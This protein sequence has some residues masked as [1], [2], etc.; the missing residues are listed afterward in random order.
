MTV[1]RAGYS[2]HGSILKVEDAGNTGTFA[3]IQ[4]VTKIEGLDIK[5]NMEESTHHESPNGWKQQAPTTIDAGQVTFELNFMPTDPTHNVGLGLLRNLTLREFKRFQLWF[6]SPFLVD[7][8][9]SGWVTNVKISLPVKGLIKA[10]VT[11]DV[12][13][14]VTLV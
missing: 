2:S 8:Q 9:F 13:G 4:Q 11:V 3:A 10:S 1:T 7:Y 6:P 5:L 14:E 12:D